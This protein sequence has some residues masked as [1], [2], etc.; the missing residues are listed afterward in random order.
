MVPQTHLISINPQ[1]FCVVRPCAGLEMLDSKATES[2]YG[3]ILEGQ[4]SFRQNFEYSSVLA[5]LPGAIGGRRYE[6][7][8]G[9]N[10]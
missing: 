10:P 9:N 1:E 6:F 8:R 2:H 3:C 5:E 4:I 7:Y